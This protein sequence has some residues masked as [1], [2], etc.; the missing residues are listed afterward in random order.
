VLAHRER[1]LA[2]DATLL[3]ADLA[4]GGRG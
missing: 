4:P 3:I 2:D 1:D